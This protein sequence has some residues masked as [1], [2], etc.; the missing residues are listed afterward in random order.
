MQMAGRKTLKTRE[1]N[2]TQRRRESDHE[3]KNTKK[4]RKRNRKK[5]GPLHSSPEQPMKFRKTRKTSSFLHLF[6][7]LFA[8]CLRFVCVFFAFFLCFF[9]VFF[10][11]FLRFFGVAFGVFFLPFRAARRS[12]RFLGA[13]RWQQNRGTCKS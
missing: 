6:C 5:T 2:R 10:C 9:G 7:I 1:K 8:F 13:R 11:V 4:T 3:K 12:W